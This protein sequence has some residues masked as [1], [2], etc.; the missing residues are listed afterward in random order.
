[1]R[2]AKSASR[3]L[4]GPDWRII[5]DIRCHIL[6]RTGNMLRL[7]MAGAMFLR[8]AVFRYGTDGS[9]DNTAQNGPL[10]GAEGCDDNNRHN[11][12]HCSQKHCACKDGCNDGSDDRTPFMPTTALLTAFFQIQ[13]FHIYLDYNFQHLLPNDT[14]Y[15]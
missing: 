11:S 3:R 6:L 9:A 14:W 8:L 5:A 12:P 4:S 7:S 13:L 10:Q 2:S 1:M 15:H